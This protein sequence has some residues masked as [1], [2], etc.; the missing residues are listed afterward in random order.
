MSFDKS[1]RN[2]EAG[3]SRGDGEDP[4]SESNEYV[5]FKKLRIIMYV[6]RAGETYRYNNILQI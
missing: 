6:E 4:V 3:E 2:G 1:R 5:I